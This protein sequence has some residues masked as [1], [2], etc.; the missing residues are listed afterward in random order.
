MP[1]L[2]G[3]RKLSSSYSQAGT[4]RERSQLKRTER[5][6][7]GEGRQAGKNRVNWEESSSVQKSEA[8]RSVEKFKQSNKLY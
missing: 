1:L 7:M 2:R 3:E 4:T 5:R 8:S 6:V